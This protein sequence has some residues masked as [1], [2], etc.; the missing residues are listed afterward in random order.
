[1][2]ARAGKIGPASAALGCDVTAPV[3]QK[4]RQRFAHAVRAVNEKPNRTAKTSGLAR[5][6]G[7]QVPV[8]G[9]ARI[10]RPA[11]FK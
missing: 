4:V 10:Q 7:D 2:Y 6:S 8:F 9:G 3:D 11:Q 5:F 1:M